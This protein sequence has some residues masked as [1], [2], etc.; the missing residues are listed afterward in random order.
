MSS[1]R[2][3]IAA[4]LAST[5][6]ATAALAPAVASP[7]VAAAPAVAP[8]FADELTVWVFPAPRPAELSWDSPGGLVRKVV[9]NAVGSMMHLMNRK[10]GH[11]SATVRCGAQAGRPARS[12]QGS[13]TNVIDAEFNDIIV[14]K[15]Y[16]LGV[17]FH[18]FTGAY[19]TA[20]D[21]QASID[22]RLPSP[23]NDKFT[24][25][26]KGRVTWL[27]YGISPMTCQRLMGWIDAFAAAGV[28]KFYGLAAAPR[29]REGAGCSA[30]SMSFLEQA[31][32][33]EPA[34]LP[35]SFDLRVPLSL[36]GG[37]L[38]G[39]KVPLLKA[40]AVTRGWAAPSEP[41]KRIFGWD[42]TQAFNWVHRQAV[43][44]IQ[45]GARVFSTP[46]WVERRGQSLGLVLDRRS[47]PTP[48]EP[49]FK[50]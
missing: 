29:L 41:H 35:W 18:N 40:L 48:T 21:T 28:N 13:M 10:L 38:T 23:K 39:K 1:L 19:E 32:I 49:Y 22:E 4:F 45:R 34:L 15:A 7:A 8:Q 25:T 9:A 26:R 14:E 17:L 2:N 42:P 30:F 36:V 43:P 20:A 11:M 24:N 16:G 46:A 3:A 27:R 44:A 47:A 37:P 5:L 50:N 6:S 31:G 12:W 33:L